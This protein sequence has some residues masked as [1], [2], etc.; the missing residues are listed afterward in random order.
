MTDE[1]ATPLASWTHT[2]ESIPQGGLKAKRTASDDERA[3]ISKALDLVSLDALTFDYAIK[4][5]G[6]GI[7]RLTGRLTARLVQSCVVTLEPVTGEIDETVEVEFRPDE[8][9]H[10]PAKG[11][12]A[13]EDDDALDVDFESETDVEPITNGR[14]EIGRIVFETL[15]GAIDPYPRKPDAAFGWKAADD[16]RSPAPNPF[17]ALAKLK[18]KS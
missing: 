12:E 5:A 1:A 17:A 2:P 4:N 16:A 15:A 8:R 10:R 13:G 6:G 7:Y 18:N 3:T 9:A 11:G 14:L